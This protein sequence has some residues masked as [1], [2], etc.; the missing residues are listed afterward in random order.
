MY[1]CGY[2]GCVVDVLWMCC[3]CVVD[4]NGEVGVNADVGMTG[5]V[6]WTYQAVFTQNTGRGRLSL[7]PEARPLTVGALLP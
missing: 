6:M 1:G 7:G 2:G 3:G 4:A 5:N